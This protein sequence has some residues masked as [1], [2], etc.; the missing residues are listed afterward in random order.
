MWAIRTSR[1][2]FPCCPPAW[3]MTGSSFI[4]PLRTNRF[5]WARSPVGTFYA[6]TEFLERYARVVWVWPGEYGTVIPKASRFA[7]TVH[8]QRSEPAFLSREYS[9]M[10]GTVGIATKIGHTGPT[11]LR[12][13]RSGDDTA[14][15]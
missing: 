3:T 9:G 5:C 13:H 2:T 1:G 6:A 15:S 7:A 8:K 12:A 11:C 4:R 14:A 10:D